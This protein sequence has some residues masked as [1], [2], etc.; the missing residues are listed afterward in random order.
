MDGV[1][2]NVACSGFVDPIQLAV[3]PLLLETI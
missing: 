2:G 3:G 1:C